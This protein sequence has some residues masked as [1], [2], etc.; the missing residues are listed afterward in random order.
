MGLGK[1]YF[2]KCRHPYLLAESSYVESLTPAGSNSYNALP[3]QKLF[4]HIHSVCEMSFEFQNVIKYEVK[5]RTSLGYE[6]DD[7]VG[8]FDEKSYR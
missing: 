2:A 5:F 4:L 7:Q 3:G 8:S 6:S 1:Y